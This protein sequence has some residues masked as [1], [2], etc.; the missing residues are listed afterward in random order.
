VRCSDIASD[1]EGWEDGELVY[2]SVMAKEE[3]GDYLISVGSDEMASEQAPK[4]DLRATCSVQLPI[5]LSQVVYGACCLQLD[6]EVELFD[7]TL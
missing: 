3:K 6:D 7:P 5:N 2:C 4:R 1:T